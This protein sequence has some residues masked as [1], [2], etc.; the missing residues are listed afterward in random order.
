[1][2]PSE[3]GISV[4]VFRAGWP[5]WSRQPH[6]RSTR[7]RKAAKVGMRRAALDDLDL[8]DALGVAVGGRLL[9]LGQQLLRQRRLP[10][11]TA[12]KPGSPTRSTAARNPR[13]EARP[14][15]G[16]CRGSWRGRPP[17][18]PG[19]GEQRLVLEE[20]DE[21]PALALGQAFACFEQA[22]AGAVELRAPGGV[23]PLRRTPLGRARA[24]RWRSPGAPRPALRW[25]RGKVKV[26][27]DDP[28]AAT[29]CG[30]PSGSRRR[31]RSR[32]LQSPRRLGA[33]ARKFQQVLS[34]S[35]SP[36]AAALPRSRE[37][38][39]H[40]QGEGHAHPPRR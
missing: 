25:R 1:V 5:W 26:I 6:A 28:R 18:A 22:V 9:A 35:R 13:G 29:P 16:P 31:G 3:G 8:D 7:W 10:W 38:G 14:R 12:S 15:C 36:P 4:L 32:R 23:W 30:W 27:A 37:P 40:R 24:W 21:S 19:L 33:H 34:G 2:V 39:V 11:A 17:S 20:L